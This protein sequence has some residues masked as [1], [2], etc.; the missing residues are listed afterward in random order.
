V[1]FKPR[2]IAQKLIAVLGELCSH[3]RRRALRL[4]RL[5]HPRNLWIGL[6]LVTVSGIAIEAW[7]V[8][9]IIDSNDT[10][11]GDLVADPPGTNANEVAISAASNPLPNAGFPHGRGI[12]QRDFPSGYRFQGMPRPTF[13][14]YAEG[15]VPEFP[16]ER[17]FLWAC[18]VNR[19]IDGCLTRTERSPTGPLEVAPGDELMI[20]ALIDN[21]GD[22]S[23]NRGGRRT[24]VA[25]NSRI[26]FSFPTGERATTL[27]LSSYIYAD[28]AVV[29]EARPVLKT[30]SDNF[31]FQSVTGNPIELRYMRDA[32]VLQARDEVS[33]D[34]GSTGYVYQRWNLTG[35]QQQMMFTG[36]RRIVMGNTEADRTLGLPIGS[37]GTLD[38]STVIGMNVNDRLDF[39]AGRAYHMFVQFKV[40]VVGAW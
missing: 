15:L 33:T 16:D 4:M 9:S 6:A 22:P 21:N 39:F 1:G 8:P 17:H 29:D 32:R 35:D 11:L 36:N 37:R 5:E 13:N 34:P 25:R 10:T 18:F 20:S 40:R 3:G 38:P 31:G 28:N 30:V 23:G 27:H 12:S 19:Q 14:S 24:A 26:L 2:K 7:I